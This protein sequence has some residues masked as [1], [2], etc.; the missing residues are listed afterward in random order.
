LGSLDSESIRVELYADA[1]QPGPAPERIVMV[2]GPLA[3]GMTKFIADVA[4]TRPLADFTP[5]AVPC[6][7]GALP[8]EEPAILW[9]R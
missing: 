5:R 3:D 7:P 2:R 9:Q 1:L 4:T 8:I 6:V